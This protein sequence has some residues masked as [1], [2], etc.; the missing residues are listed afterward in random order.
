MIQS[1]FKIQKLSAQFFE[2]YF[3]FLTEKFMIEAVA[4]LLTIKAHK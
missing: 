4:S 3:K 2:T 1:Q